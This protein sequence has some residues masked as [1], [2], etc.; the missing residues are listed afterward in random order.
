[1]GKREGAERLPQPFRE[2]FELAARLGFKFQKSEGRTT[3][4]D[5]ERTEQTSEEEKD[6][7]AH[8]NKASAKASHLAAKDEGDDVE[9]HMHKAAHKA[10]HK[11]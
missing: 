3:V 8:G 6:V 11:Y 2:D 5:Q 7:E 10:V 9:G 4:E 1:M